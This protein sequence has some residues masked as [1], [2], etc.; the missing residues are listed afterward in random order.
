MDVEAPDDPIDVLR[1]WESAG[2]VWRVAASTA[3]S[4]TI[5]LCTCDGGEEV[6]RFHSTDPALVDF[7]AS[8]GGDPANRW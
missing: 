3:S 4:V 8:T 2:A 5:S 1:R 7:V 6:S